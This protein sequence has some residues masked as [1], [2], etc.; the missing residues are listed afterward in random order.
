[1]G[2]LI[3]NEVISENTNLFLAFL[4][5][6]GFGFVLEASGFSSSR[7][8][9]GVF[10]GYDMV[11]LKVF[12]T[13][14]I[15]AMLGL[16][17]FSLFGWVDLNLVYINPTYLTSAIL[18]GAIMGAGFIIGGYCPGTSFCG[19]S[20][21]KLDAL[22]FIIGL[23]I[24]VGI[25]GAG[26]N[27]WEGLYMAKFLGIPKISTTLGITDGVFALILIIVALGMFKA[28]EWIEKKFPRTEY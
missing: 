22:V 1:M 19:L 15:T 24:G 27:W 5:G 13:G 9:A 25:F 20:I 17:F 16:L 21:G 4:I 26:F 12:F 3:V 7:K 14:A 6:I 11:V 23:F 28:A 18:G 2:P 10:Y 8:L